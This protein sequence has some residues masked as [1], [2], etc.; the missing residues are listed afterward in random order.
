MN[1]LCLNEKRGIYITL[2]TVNATDE[3]E[4]INS[5]ADPGFF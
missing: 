3:K 2:F 4:Y 1:L 5:G